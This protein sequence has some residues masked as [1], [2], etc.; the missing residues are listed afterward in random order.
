[1]KIKGGWEPAPDMIYAVKMRNGVRRWPQHQACKGLGQCFYI[2]S[3]YWPYYLYYLNFL[4][5]LEILLVTEVV[6]L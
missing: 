6:F 1:M 2:Y 3:I 5:P 4:L